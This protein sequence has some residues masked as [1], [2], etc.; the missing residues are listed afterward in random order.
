MS[1]LIDAITVKSQERADR[2]SNAMKVLNDALEAQF[3]W[4]VDYE[5]VKYWLTRGGEDGL[6]ELRKQIGYGDAFPKQIDLYD[7]MDFTSC[8]PHEANSRLKK[9]GKYRGQVN[10]SVDT[11]LDALV[12]LA[13][14][15]AKMKTVKGFIKKGRKP[16]EN[17]VQ[18][19]LTHT[20]HCAICGKLHK[21][22]KGKKL[23]NHGY[24]RPGDGW[25][26]GEC[27][28]VGYAPY[29]LSHEANDAFAVML[30]NALTKKET[31]L[32]VLLH[33]EVNKFYK[34]VSERV[35]VDGRWKHVDR[36]VLVKRGEEGFDDLEL[37][38]IDNVEADINGIKENIGWNNSKIA[39]WVLKPLPYGEAK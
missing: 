28:G 25:L 9:L 34:S 1:I 19:D 38:A 36:L 4:N 24:E 35:Q 26:H 16:A 20:G 6:S 23:V 39:A 15:G 31:Y 10:Q 18:P 3:I 21:L 14:I 33:H 32:G 2:F 11:F 17:P 13:E 27:F 7:Q 22:T 12:E 29:E 8:Y 30:T 5:S 37:N